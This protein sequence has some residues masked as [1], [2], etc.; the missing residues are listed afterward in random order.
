MAVI[1]GVPSDDGISQHLKVRITQNIGGQ[2]ITVVGYLSESCEFSLAASWESPFAGDTLGNAGK[3]EKTAAIAQAES[4]LT[5]KTKYNSQQVWEGNEP[6][7]ISM[8]LRFLAFTD[9]KKEVDDPIMY[10]LQMASPQLNETLP[11]DLSGLGRVPAEAIFDIGRLH[12]FGMRISNVS[13]DLNAP[14]TKDG[15]FLS[16]AVSITAAPKQIF[17]RSDFPRLFK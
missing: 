1:V 7:E 8:T 9:A 11:I 14:R 12:K 3:I 2:D 13:F 15:H 17:N 10:L 5:S 6:P 4:E 16:N